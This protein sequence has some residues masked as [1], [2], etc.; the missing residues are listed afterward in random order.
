[1]RFSLKR[2]LETKETVILLILIQYSNTSTFL[3]FIIEFLQ[4]FLE[5]ASM[6]S[7]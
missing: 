7:L 5:I 2:H 4:I 6:F 3:K 1:M